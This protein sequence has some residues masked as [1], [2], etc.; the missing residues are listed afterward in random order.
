VILIPAAQSSIRF[1]HIF[2]NSTGANPTSWS[3]I[4]EPL[5]QGLKR[6]RYQAD[7]SPLSSAEV[8]KEWSPNSS[9]LFAFMLWW[10]GAVLSPRLL[11]KI[12]FII[13][14]LRSWD[15]SVGIGTRYGLV[16]AGIEFRWRR[17]FP[18]PSTPDLGLT[19]SPIQWVPGL[20]RW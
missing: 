8:R 20:S 10:S 12:L 14:S 19:Q 3:L 11:C 15:S 16:G 4:P 9:P 17:D 7:H 6:S 2:L 13:L 1:P 18:Q 5:S